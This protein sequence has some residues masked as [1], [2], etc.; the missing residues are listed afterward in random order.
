MNGKEGLEI[1]TSTHP[2]VGFSEVDYPSELHS[3]FPLK[4]GYHIRN[5]RAVALIL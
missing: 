3:G 5:Y 4:G 1:D 2:S